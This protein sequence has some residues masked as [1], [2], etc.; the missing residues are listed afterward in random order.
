M[1]GRDLFFSKVA[2]LYRYSISDA[3]TANSRIISQ[4]LLGYVS[5]I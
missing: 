5:L 3:E 1:N 4:Y 2:A